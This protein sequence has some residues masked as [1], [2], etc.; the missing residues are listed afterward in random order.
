MVKMTN[1]QGMIFDNCTMTIQGTSPGQTPPC[2]MFQLSGK[3]RSVN[4]RGG[5]I[6]PGLFSTSWGIDALYQSSTNNPYDSSGEDWATFTNVHPDTNSAGTALFNA[7]DTIAK[8]TNRNFKW[9]RRVNIENNDLEFGFTSTSNKSN[10]WK[11]PSLAIDTSSML[12][13]RSLS[14]LNVKTIGYGE[15]EQFN[16][17]AK[18]NSSRRGLYI[19]TCDAPYGCCALFFSSGSDLF[20]LNGTDTAANTGKA[21]VKVNVSATDAGTPDQ[22]SVFLTGGANINVTNRSGVL[23]SRKFSLIMIG[24]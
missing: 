18:S 22:V 4:F 1:V 7:N 2:A 24:F 13:V 8:S 11:T 3:V 19:L 17:P 5:H 23:G 14:S 20:L 12:K 16:F 15:T 10:D 9:N 21:T 6:H